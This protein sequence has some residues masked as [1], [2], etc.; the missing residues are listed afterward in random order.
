M[1][2]VERTGI[3]SDCFPARVFISCGQRKD[4]DEIQVAKD[5]EA[6]LRKIG[7]DPY[8]AIEE[9]TLRGITENLFRQIETSEYFIFIDF[10]REYIDEKK[11]YRG[12]LFSHQELALATYFRLPIIAFREKGVISEDGI[13]NALQANSSEF[14]DRHHL[15]DIIMA[16]VKDRGWSPEGQRELI[17]RRDGSQFVDA[18]DKHK[19]IMR[20]FH[21][22]VINHHK[23]K[24]AIGCY[25]YL[26]Q[27]SNATTSDVVFQETV[28]VKW[29]GYNFP[30]ANIAPQSS[31]SFDALFITSAQPFIAQPL[32]FTDYSNYAPILSGPGEY[33]FRFLV[34]AENYPPARI[35]L[36]LCL[37]SHL[38]HAQLIAAG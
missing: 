36:R 19:G 25:A 12:S 18:N 38:D 30:M 28:E 26:E 16:K 33:N 22:N 8:V 1:K 3:L 32:V 14:S 24:P 13:M 20:V 21:V 9:Q 7:F 34:L 5:L 35:Q 4:T 2:E 31:R 17:L 37:G 10:K 27:I 29:T 15:K 23:T 6:A 11:A